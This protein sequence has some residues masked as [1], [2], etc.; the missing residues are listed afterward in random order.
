MIE[1]PALPEIT[2]EVPADILASPALLFLYYRIDHTLGIK[3]KGEALKKLN[4]YIEENCGFTFTENP[5][6][7]ENF[8]ASRENIFNVSKFLTVNETY[9]FREGVHFKLL[10]QLLPQL[11]KPGRPLQICSAAVSAGCEAY[12]IAMLLDFN[13]KNGLE[14]DFEIDAFDVNS[15]AIETA[16]NGRYTSNAFRKDGSDWKYIYDKYLIQDNEDFLVSQDIVKKVRFFN[17][18]IMNCLE[19]KYDIVF[20]KNALIYFSLKNRQIV[21]N[22]LADA[23]FPGGF[24]FLGLSET[25]SVKHPLLVS[26]FSSDTFYFQRKASDYLSAPVSPPAAQAELQSEKNYSDLKKPD[27]LK[28][29]RRPHEDE[30]IKNELSVN[31]S[32]I[33]EILKTEEGKSNA[34]KIIALLDENKTNSVSGSRLAA[35]VIYNLNS[36][37]FDNADKILSFFEKNSTG[38]CVNFLRG[39]YHFL[40]DDNESAEHYYHTASV[41]DK[42]FWP[43]F[44]RLTLL[45]APGNQTRYNYKIKKAIESIELLQNTKPQPEFNYEC[46]MGGFSPDYFLGILEK[47]LI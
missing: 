21:I 39:D 16:K 13:I 5:A 23:L 24:L 29:G 6:H 2:T 46:F 15:E 9:F 19:K 37:H 45:Y 47:K 27:N 1:N 3:T 4:E 31:Y 11:I 28:T 44:Y 30:K 8:L 43:A 22:N 35:A 7:Y 12:S 17:H 18:N 26:V 34:E 36:Q 41:K 20:F 33:S 32:E 42:L 38:A 25:S 10:E 14:F 40:Q